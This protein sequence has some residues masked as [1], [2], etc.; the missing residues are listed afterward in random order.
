MQSNRKTSAWSAVN[1]K[2]TADRGEPAIW[3]R[4]T[5]QQFSMILFTLAYIE[6]LWVDVRTYGR[7]VDDVMAIKRK[8]LASM[9][10]R[11]SLR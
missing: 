8:F 4:E 1:L 10:Y 6:A 3:S 11:I 7:T 9:G 2:K 5:G